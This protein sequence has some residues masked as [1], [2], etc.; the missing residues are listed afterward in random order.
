M[1]ISNRESKGA[2]PWRIVAT[3]DFPLRRLPNTIFHTNL[4][5]EANT[6]YD[7]SIPSWPPRHGHN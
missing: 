7:R 3:A 4:C 6:A 5:V 2:E 1:G